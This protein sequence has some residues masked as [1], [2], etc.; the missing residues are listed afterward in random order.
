MDGPLDCHYVVCI[1]RSWPFEH[2]EANRMASCELSV[3]TQY[4][5]LRG[6]HTG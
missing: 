2:G 5:V 1:R 4:P 6:V 3:P